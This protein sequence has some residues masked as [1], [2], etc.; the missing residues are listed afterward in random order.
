MGSEVEHLDHAESREARS[1]ARVDRRLEPDATAGERRVRWDV[2]GD[3]TNANWR[4]PDPRFTVDPRGNNA[5]GD[6]FAPN[7]DVTITRG[8]DAWPA[9]TDGNGSFGVDFGPHDF[10]GGD[11][12]TVAD[13]QE[14]DYMFVD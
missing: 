8:G 5:W 13:G 12:V 14:I 9:T 7:T 10:Q 2:D 4:V 3:S 11:Y 1:R 6:D